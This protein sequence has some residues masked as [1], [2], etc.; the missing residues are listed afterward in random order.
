MKPL[1]K[2]GE[3]DTERDRET[4][5]ATETARERSKNNPTSNFKNIN[6][7]TPENCPISQIITFDTCGQTLT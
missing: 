1:K 4:E 3:R 5:I 6:S 2:G 7:K